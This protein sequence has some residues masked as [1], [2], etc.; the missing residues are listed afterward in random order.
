MSRSKELP[1]N[2]SIC[3][4]YHPPIHKFTQSIHLSNMASFKL[5]PGCP[6]S[7]SRHLGFHPL[8]HS[9]IQL[10]I[11]PAHLPIN[12]PTDLIIHPPSQ[13]LFN[14]LSLPPINTSSHQY[15][16]QLSKYVQPVQL[17]LTISNQSDHNHWFNQLICYPTRASVRF[18]LPRNI[19]STF[20]SFN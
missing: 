16:L 12:P 2:P 19:H 13:S 14:Q 4:I 15:Y 11:W 5:Y 17:L 18:T 20:Q 9:S 10:T 8:V 1:V 6:F 3:S 7:L